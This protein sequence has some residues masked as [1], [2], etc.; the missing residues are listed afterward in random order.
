MIWRALL[1]VVLVFTSAYAASSPQTDDPCLVARTMKER[2]F[3][4][5]DNACKQTNPQGGTTE[6]CITA[7]MQTIP[8]EKAY[9]ACRWDYQHP[10]KHTP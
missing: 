3:A 6:V 4:V 10:K 7:R 5:A 9:V 2:A 8:A 1:L